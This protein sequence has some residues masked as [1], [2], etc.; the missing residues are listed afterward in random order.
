[1]TKSANIESIEK[2]TGISWED[3]LK[4]LDKAGAH[5]MSH[6]DIAPL[7]MNAWLNQGYLMTLQLIKIIGKIHP[8]GGRRALQWRT[9]STLAAANPASAPTAVLKFR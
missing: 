7:S 8:V 4:F 3:W 9:N 1:M 6:P 2:A 5:S